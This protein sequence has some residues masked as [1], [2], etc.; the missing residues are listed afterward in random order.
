MRKISFSFT[1][2]IIST[3]AFGQHKLIPKKVGFLYNFGNEKNFLFDDEDYFYTTRTYKAQLFYDLFNFK[4]LAISLIVQP[5]IQAIKH[6]LLNEQFVRPEEY[7]YIAKRA[8]Y[9]T[10]KNINLYAL[11][12]GLSAKIKLFKPLSFDITTGLGLSYI[13]KTTERLAEGFTF[14]ENL[15]L[16]FTIATSTKTYLYLGGNIGHVSNFDFQAPNNGYN[17]AGFEIGLQYL[18]K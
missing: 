7:N 14:I 10:L 12:F 3:I 5:Q 2:L 13:N 6:Q 18:L 15:S 16:G 4:R 1:F 9:T 11:E 17:I 8:Q